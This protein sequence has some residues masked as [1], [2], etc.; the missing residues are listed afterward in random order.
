MN[1]I[2]EMLWRVVAWV[3]TRK[4]VLKTI[5]WWAH[6]RPYVNIQSA[7]GLDVYMYRH[8]VFNQYHLTGSHEF[9]PRHI[10]W[11]PSIR[12]HRIMRADHDRHF[13]SHPWE[14]RTIILDSPEG[15]FGYAEERPQWADEHAP[16]DLF[17]RKVGYTG[18]I[19]FG[20]YHRITR[21]PEGGVLTLF[22][23]FEKLASW[24]FL[25]DRKE[26]NFKQYFKEY[27]IPDP[28]ADPAKRANT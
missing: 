21:V 10:P 24:G 26:V 15:D 12:L 4:P 8:W 22:I 27:G 28:A 11:L 2:S 25:V 13:H 9:N 19:G 17:I 3:V 20:Q 16:T 1:R 23:T 6:R 18:R 7:D 14:A 5:V